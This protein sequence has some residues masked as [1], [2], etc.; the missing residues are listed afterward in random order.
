[1]AGH[2]GRRSSRSAAR[3]R[4]VRRAEFR[5]EIRIVDRRRTPPARRSPV[6]G[7][8]AEASARPARREGARH[9]SGRLARGSAPRRAAPPAPSRCTP[10]SAAPEARSR[11]SDRGWDRAHRHRRADC[12]GA[13]RRPPARR[14]RNRA[15][16]SGARARSAAARR[17]SRDRTP[18]PARAGRAARRSRP[19]APPGSSRAAGRR[20][21]AA[22]PRPRRRV[23]ARSSRPERSATISRDPRCRGIMA[24]RESIPVWIP[25]PRIQQ[26]PEEREI[27]AEP[28]L[29]EPP[30][31]CS[32][33]PL[34]HLR[35]PGD[36]SA[37]VAVPAVPGLSGR[38]VP[39]FDRAARPCSWRS[40]SSCSPVTPGS[41]RCRPRTGSS[42]SRS[43]CAWRAPAA[44]PEAA[45]RRALAPASS[46]PSASPATPSCRS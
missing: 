37:L 32:G 33:V 43:A 30:E 14:G 2:A 27:M 17:A 36:Q 26:L 41:S 1:M 45:H 18:A 23:A 34:R 6:A 35:H 19:P 5:L 11:G 9:R 25:G 22:P 21:R 4:G 7:E 24:P 28:D 20:I 38:G 40:P 15:E 39:F 13:T 46:S 8:A 29:R 10:A 31:V 16:R 3:G 12:A 44:G 42:A